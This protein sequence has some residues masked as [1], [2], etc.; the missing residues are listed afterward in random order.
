[1]HPGNIDKPST[2]AGRVYRVLRRAR[3]SWVSGW[4]LTVQSRTSA[5]STRVSEIRLRFELEPKRGLAIESNQRGQHWYYRIVD[6]KT[7]QLELV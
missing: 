7:G 6:V 5:V 4:D 2:G 1:M 3:G